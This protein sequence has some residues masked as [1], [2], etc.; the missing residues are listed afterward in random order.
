MLVMGVGIMGVSVSERSM[1]VTVGM[2]GARWHRCAML[3]LM[4]FVVLVPVLVL[5]NWVSMFV[6]MAFGQMQPDA[7]GHQE[8]RDRQARCDRL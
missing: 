2:T 6:L 7:C 1:A 8:R 4:M 3:M 5:E